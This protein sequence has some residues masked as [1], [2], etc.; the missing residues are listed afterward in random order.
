MDTI[1]GYVVASSIRDRKLTNTDIG[2][3]VKNI[4]ITNE[5][6]FHKLNMVQ[7]NLS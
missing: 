7:Q 4:R 5:P 2:R 3:P 6:R 1:N